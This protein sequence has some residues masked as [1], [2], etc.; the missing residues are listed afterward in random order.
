M[1]VGVAAYLAYIFVYVGVDR[2]APLLASANGVMILL[3]ILFLLVSVILHGLSWYILI[4]R[5][6]REIPRVLSTM[7]VSLFAS[8][9]APIGAASEFVRF[10]VATRIIGINAATAVL[11]ILAHRVCITLAPLI[12][13]TSLMLYLRGDLVV[14]E[15]AAITTIILVYVSVIVLPNI[16]AIGLIRTRIFE[17]LIKRYEKHLS[18]IIGGDVINFSEEYRRSMAGLISGPRF[19]LALAVSLAEWFFLAAS[20]YAIFMALSLKKDVIIAAASI[21]MIQILW[22]V[23]P[24]S[25]AGSIGI[26]DLLAS[27]AYQLLSFEP[28][29]S[30]SIVLLYRLSSLTALLILFYPSLRILGM[31]PR[32]FKKIYGEDGK[33]NS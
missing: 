21:I 5:G 8:Y 25:F 15:R 22:W 24:I 11:S 3:S 28:G 23:L 20:M 30:A 6:G 7:V 32:E 17:K 13:L 31:Y 16:L 19:P 12:A 29:V 27:I 18:R 2:L 1:I 4:D 33:I 26:T 9:V 10:F 14:V